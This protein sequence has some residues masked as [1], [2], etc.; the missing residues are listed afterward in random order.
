VA[1]TSF[2]K[3][4]NSQS[5][6]WSVPWLRKENAATTS[7]GVSSKRILRQYFRWTGSELQPCIW[8]FV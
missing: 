2:T 4:L 6:R 7:A 1:V 3:A 8:G 5:Q